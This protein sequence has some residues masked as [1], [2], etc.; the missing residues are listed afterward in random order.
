MSNNR[1]KTTKSQKSSSRNMKTENMKT[2]DNGI[3]L[4]WSQEPL[5]EDSKS[6]EFII[7]PKIVAIRA[8]GKSLLSD[9]PGEIKLFVPFSHM[10]YLPKIASFLDR[11]SKKTF[12]FNTS[13]GIAVK[14]H[15]V[16]SRLAKFLSRMKQDKSLF[17]W[18]DHLKLSEIIPTES[19]PK[20]K[21]KEIKD[22][23]PS[24]KPKVIQLESTQVVAKVE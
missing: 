6:I 1:N 23:K 8:D 18:N 24:D 12:D 14:S 11:E 10:S 2:H 4:S 9:Y 22:D 7:T 5:K 3:R 17:A 19:S 16:E 21:S 20:N 13:E 15:S